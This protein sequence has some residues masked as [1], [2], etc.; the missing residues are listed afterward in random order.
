MFPSV[1]SLRGMSVPESAEVTGK[2]R[3]MYS[4][5]LYKFCFSCRIAG[6]I[7]SWMLWVRHAACVGK[8][9]RFL[10]FLLLQ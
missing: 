1:N 2:W 8:V 10:L 5:K 7:N 4:E 6:V 9:D 3:K